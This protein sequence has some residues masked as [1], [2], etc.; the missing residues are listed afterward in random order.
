MDLDRFHAH[1]A[2]REDYPPISALFQAFCGADKKPTRQAPEQPMK[3]WDRA[4]S[5]AEISA[6]EFE[7]FKKQCMIDGIPLFSKIPGT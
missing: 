2:Y 1:L 4:K 3:D 5:E 6:E 7:K